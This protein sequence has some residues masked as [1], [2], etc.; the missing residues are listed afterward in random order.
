MPSADPS[1]DVGYCLS[2]ALARAKARA[3]SPMAA[4]AVLAGVAF[5]LFGQLAL[6][7]VGES[8]F[9]ADQVDQ[10]QK[11]EALLRLDPEGLWGPAMSG[12]AARAL[13][14]F[15]AVV[16]GLPVALGFGIDAIHAFTSLLLV[17]TAALA[18]WQ[19][20]RLDVPMAWVWLIVFTAMRLVWWNAAMFWVNATLLPLGLLM[21]ALFAASVRKP[22]IVT[23]AGLTCVQMLGLQQHLVAIVGVPVVLLAIVAF[24]LRGP[25]SA[26]RRGVQVL[27]VVAI[28][29]AAGLL[30][31]AIAEGRT[32]F[33]NTR[34]MFTQIDAAVHASSADGRHAA[35]ETLVVATGPVLMVSEPMPMV[36][37]TA[38]SAVALAAVA[39]LW[40]RRAN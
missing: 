21:L 3:T 25:G 20:A 23:L 38:G 24:V 30:P 1:V 18:F 9:L 5:V 34:A 31:Y 39:L 7:H 27:V 2:P 12:T 22:T 14:P 36:A 15:G 4:T 29:I 10:L 19:L 11:F 37:L 8:Y 26:S 32:G 6:R 35:V 16:F 33:R 40:R 17:V 13:G 28:V